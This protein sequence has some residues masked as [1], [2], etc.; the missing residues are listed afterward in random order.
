MGARGGGPESAGRIGGDDR[1]KETWRE[2]RVRDKAEAKSRRKERVGE[3]ERKMTVW[4]S[5]AKAGS[6]EEKGG[7]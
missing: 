1:E 5:R 6:D 3:R 7:H 2:E 4:T